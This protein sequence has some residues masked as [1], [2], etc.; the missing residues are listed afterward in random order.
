MTAPARWGRAEIAPVLIPWGLAVVVTL[1]AF[2]LASEIA[3]RVPG[4][5]SARPAFT[6]YDANWYVTIATQGYAASPHETLR[7]FPLF[8]LLERFVGV[9]IPG[10]PR[11]AGLVI[12]NVAA[13]VY[14]ASVRALARVTADADLADRA[15]WFLLLAPVGFVLVTGY[16]EALSGAVVAGALLAA[17]RQRWWIA[18]VLGAVAGLA[19]PVGVLLAVPLAVEAARHW[20]P[21]PTAQ[22]VARCVA[23]LAPAAGTAVYLGW[24]AAVYHSPLL[25][26]RLQASGPRAALIGNPLAPLKHSA[27]A[28]WHGVEPT[29]ALNLPAVVVS[30]VLLVVCART[31]PASYTAFA[32][33]TVAAAVTARTL[34]SFERYAASAFPL[35]IAL[36]TLA[37][38]RQAFAGVLALG[39]A[40][41]V[42]Y[43]TLAFLRLYTP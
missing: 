9:V 34:D 35:A 11:V 6:L 22:R 42:F 7:F 33:L 24:V 2:V 8:P 43:A 12:T 18:G 4:G 20:S 29:V 16:A 19:R 28:A 30:L 23:V 17:R 25:P 26:Y 32:V 38:R 36:G 39:A 13:V 5:A 40:L 31:L 14:A 10:G 1:A 21:A 3:R 15:V 27:I 41:C 37:R